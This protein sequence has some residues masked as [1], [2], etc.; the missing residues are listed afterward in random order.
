MSSFK[1]KGTSK[2]AIPTYAG[3]RIC[4]GAVQTL[5][6][7][8]G[9]SSLDDILGGGLALS[10]SLVVAAPDLHSSYGELVLKY[11][12]AQGLI[13]GHRVCVVGGAQEELGR[14]VK[15]CMWVTN[16]NAEDDEDEGNGN[17]QAQKIMIAWRYEKMKQFKTTVGSSWNSYVTIS[18]PSLVSFFFDLTS[19]YHR[20]GAS[21][22]QAFD[23]SSTIP[24]EA[25]DDGLKTDRLHLID[26]SQ[27]PSISGVLEEVTRYL[28]SDTSAPVRIC[29]PNL[30]SPVWGDLTAQVGDPR[31]FTISS[32]NTGMRIDDK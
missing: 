32:S 12:V 10:C 29:I 4:P 2:P 21:Y 20:D 5:L 8:T 6:T 23:L 24:E 15:E 27:N 14:F 19:V 28:S 26:V 22:C 31:L 25:I 16:S 30:G 13:S 3:T 9:I 1:R 7:S 17:D 18:P 11:F